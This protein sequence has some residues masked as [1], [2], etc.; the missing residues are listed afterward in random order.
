[1]MAFRW[2]PNS[3]IHSKFTVSSAAIKDL[4]VL[5]KIRG[6]DAV[7]FFTKILVS[8]GRLLLTIGMDSQILNILYCT[9]CVSVCV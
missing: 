4:F 6:E 5:K 1:M 9:L 2:I 3:S 8:C 7:K